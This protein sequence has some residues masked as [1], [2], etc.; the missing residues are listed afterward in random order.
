[1]AN[2]FLLL[3]VF[4]LSLVLFS[5]GSFADVL[6][7]D[8]DSDTEVDMNMA[9]NSADI[10]TGSG[11]VGDYVLLVCSISPFFQDPPVF[12]NPT[13]GDWEEL[14]TGLCGGGTT[15]SHGIWGS[16]IDSPA[17]EEITCSWD[18]AGNVFAA[19]TF[20]YNN[21]D[22]DDPIIDVACQSGTGNDAI[23]PSI[24]T[25][26]GS[27]VVRIFTY[28]NLDGTPTS[29]SNSNTDTEGQFSAFATTTFQNVSLRGTTDFSPVAEATGEANNFSGT[30]PQWRACTIALRMAPDAPS[31][32]PTMSEWGLIS[33]ATFAGIAGL[34][35]LRRRQVTA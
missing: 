3:S 29:D 9:F 34:W 11:L 1:M 20:R 32:V 4:I 14:D 25:E 21:V 15:C 31:A 12:S 7:E 19:G 5:F 2:K 16:F 17:N 26:A 23:A 24:E 10:G 28:F 18:D 33:F 8:A 35:Y 27:Q 30:E 6:V 22:T 13:P